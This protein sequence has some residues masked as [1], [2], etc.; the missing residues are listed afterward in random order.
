MNP[1]N[2]PLASKDLNKGVCAR[3]KDAGAPNHIFATYFH[4]VSIAAMESDYDF[5]K[6]PPEIIETKS[7]KLAARLVFEFLKRTNLDLTRECVEKEAQSKL[8]SPENKISTSCLQITKARPPIQKLVRQRYVELKNDQGENSD[9]WFNIDSEVTKTLSESDSDPV[10]ELPKEVAD[11]EDKRSY[12]VI[13]PKKE[14]VYDSYDETIS[15]TMTSASMQS[16][17]KDPRKQGQQQKEEIVDS[18]STSEVF[19]SRKSHHR[20]HRETSERSERSHRS[21]KSSKSMKSQQGEEQVK[22]EPSERSVKS[23]KNQQNEEQSLRSERSHRSMKS[24]K[25]DEQDE[26]SEGSIKSLKSERSD[27]SKASAKSSH[28]S[29]RAE[30]ENDAVRTR[31]SELSVSS[32]RH[33]RV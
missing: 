28:H 11:E 5:F 6:L 30:N 7:Q 27:K 10:F 12:R 31:D 24:Q 14:K 20:S 9:G 26:Q 17:A 29:R 19:S 8:F 4:D 2:L 16:D 3:M 25:V 22:D 32:R 13:K 33:N 23:L 1:N 21:E 18:E 15:V